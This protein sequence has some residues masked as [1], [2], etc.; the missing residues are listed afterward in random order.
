MKI[1]ESIEQTCGA[2]PESWSGKLTTGEIVY[3]R[4]RWGYGY[5]DIDDIT[6]AEYSVPDD[7]YLG[8]FPEGELKRMFESADIYTGSLLDK[9]Y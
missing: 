5:L 9:N 3:A 6:V 2:C 1:L 4:M 8:M 7:T